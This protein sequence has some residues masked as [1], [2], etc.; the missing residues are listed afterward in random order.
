MAHVAGAKYKCNK[1]DCM[2]NPCH[3]KYANAGFKNLD[4]LV[5]HLVLAHGAKYEALG[6]ADR[7]YFAQ[8]LL[9]DEEMRLDDGTAVEGA[10]GEVTVV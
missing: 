1:R 4:H 6:R 10:A 8:Y 3:S 2:Y 5:V 9:S 7:A